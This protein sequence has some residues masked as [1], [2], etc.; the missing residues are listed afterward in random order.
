MSLHGCLFCR[1]DDRIKDPDVRAFSYMAIAGM[2]EQ[3]HKTPW[4]TYTDCCRKHAMVSV[5]ATVALGELMISML[6]ESTPPGLEAHAERAKQ[7]TRKLL[8][9]LEIAVM[10]KYDRKEDGDSK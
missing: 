8:A 1:I 4:P 7:H 2:A 9:E 5:K 6:D 3:V 10:D